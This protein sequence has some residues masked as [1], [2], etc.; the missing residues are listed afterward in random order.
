MFAALLDLP[1]RPADTCIALAIILA[2]VFGPRW[3]ARL[4]GLPAPA[5]RRALLWL[6]LAVIVGARL[7][8]LL[9]YGA[10][11]RGRLL[12]AVLPWGGFHIGGGIIAM[13]L[14][15]PWVTRRY[16]LPL[17]RFADAIAPTVAF[18]V[19]GAR[20]GCFLQGCCFGAQCSPAHGIHFP[21]GAPAFEYHQQQGWIAADALHSLPVHPLQLYFIAAALLIL[22]VSWWLSAHKRWDGQVA[23]VALLL[24]SASTAGLEVLR[25]DIGMRVYW[26]SLPQLTWT[27]LAM[28]L[29]SLAALIA[30]SLAQRRQRPGSTALHGGSGAAPLAAKH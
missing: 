23:L 26:G 7:H 8:F 25:A 9:N 11:Y 10:A 14:I 1:L 27:A 19:A 24:F 16:G 2:L 29:A 30:G 15:M 21:P 5:V 20:L 4:A 13:V 3:A 18:G 28:T 6:S 22:A 12:E 17:G